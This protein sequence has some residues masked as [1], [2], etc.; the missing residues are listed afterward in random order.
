MTSEKRVLIAPKDILGIGFD[1]PHCRSTYFAPV[2]TLDRIVNNCPNCQQHWLS[3]I[4]TSSDAHSDA[5]TFN[6]F[7]DF[8]RELRNR[9]FGDS[10]RFEIR[11]EEKPEVKV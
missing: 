2:G 5:T 7:V 8:L 6:F 10:V 11:C 9:P 4:Q 3:G 1:C